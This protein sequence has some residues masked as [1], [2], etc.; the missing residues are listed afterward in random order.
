MGVATTASSL[1]QLKRFTTVVAAVALALLPAPAPAGG[2]KDEPT[3]TVSFHLQTTPDPS[4]Q[5]TFTQ[6]TAGEQV[7]YRRVP[8]IATRDIVAFSPFPGDDGQTYGVVF[9]LNEP[10]TRR[11]SSI[12]AANQGRYLLAIVNGQVRDAV[13]IDRPVNDGLIVIWRWVTLQEIRLA[14]S[15]LPRI[16]E[17]PKAWKERQKNKK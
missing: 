5:R 10:A 13:I 11:L 2:R 12:S 1:D 4:R 9:Q 15:L 14:D 3:I 17:D 8:E 7:V 16:G 6:P